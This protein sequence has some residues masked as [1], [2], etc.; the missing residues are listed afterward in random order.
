MRASQ[1]GVDGKDQLAGAD[2][3]LR[4]VGTPAVLLQHLNLSVLLA[5][6][7]VDLFTVYGDT[8]QAFLGFRYLRAFAFKS[9]KQPI[10]NL[11]TAAIDVRQR[12]GA[13]LIRHGSRL[14]VASR[15]RRS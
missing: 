6:L 5:D 3:L 8:K 11:V 1:I 13:I 10:E 7:K 4:A 12:A 2:E 14:V 15:R 9:A